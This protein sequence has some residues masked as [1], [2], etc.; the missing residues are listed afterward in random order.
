MDEM[1][2]LDK[3][4]YSRDSKLDLQKINS[5]LQMFQH[6]LHE[7]KVHIA[8][9]LRA[10][11]F[12]DIS[13]VFQIQI[14]K[15]FDEIVGNLK[16]SLAKLE[17]K[18]DDKIKS[19]E[20]RLDNLENENWH[21]T[22][23]QKKIE[24]NAL[25]NNEKIHEFSISNSKLTQMMLKLNETCSNYENG[26]LRLNENIQ[27]INRDL[28][29]VKEGFKF[30]KEN[31]Y[32]ALEPFISHINLEFS[33]DHE[34]MNEIHTEIDRLKS[35]ISHLETRQEK[36]DQLSELL[37]GMTVRDDHTKSRIIYEQL[38]DSIKKVEADQIFMNS[39]IQK[40]EQAEEKNI[41]VR[42]KV[43]IR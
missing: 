2:L 40:L 12:Q 39:K 37:K 16:N 29:T 8:Y 18:I 10:V 11:L 14:A 5:T 34:K 6:N 3:S 1:S 20:N 13:N 32:F 17:T 30:L 23:I 35:K 41:K 7:Q 15:G 9:E 26:K 36:P 31:P 33:K 43:N 42:Q 24:N 38:G 27:E 19:I 25:K 21:Q 4:T 28:D 22:Q